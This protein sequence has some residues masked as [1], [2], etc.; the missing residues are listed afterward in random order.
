MGL[1]SVALTSVLS[2]QIAEYVY[3]MLQMAAQCIV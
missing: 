2:W 1:Y 3:G